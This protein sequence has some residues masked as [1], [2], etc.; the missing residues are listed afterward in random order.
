MTVLLLLPKRNK[1]LSLLINTICIILKISV[2][3][4]SNFKSKKTYLIFSI[5]NAS[6]KSDLSS[7]QT[8]VCL[9]EQADV[10]TS[11]FH[12]VNP[13]LHTIVNN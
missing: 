8:S 7:I 6:L 9:L 5:L 4:H 3:F 10:F 1:T 12:L 2:I 11:P 13:W